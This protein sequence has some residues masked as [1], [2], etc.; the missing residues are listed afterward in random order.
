MR[1]MK[2]FPGTAGPFLLGTAAL[3]VA[4]LASCGGE[5]SERGVLPGE[6]P[7][8]EV[9]AL[10]FDPVGGRLFKVHPHALY[11]SGDGGRSWDPVPLPASVLDGR[12]A[13]IALPPD[14]AGAL[15]VAG[16][17]IGVIVSRDMG[18]TWKGIGQELP[19]DLVALTGHADQPRTLYAVVEEEGIFR[20]QDAG[21]TWTRMDGGPGPPIW[22]FVHT[23]MEGSMQSGWLFAATPE[24]VRRS[25]DCFCGW[26]PTADLPSGGAS[27]VTYDPRRPERVYAS[28]VEG[29]F[30]SPDGGETWERV[31]QEPVATALAVDP[32]TGALYAAVSGGALLRSADEG[33]TWLRV[34]A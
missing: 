7:P 30:L 29:I 10:E 6:A 26:R 3:L 22:A 11:G 20:S 31:S 9:I 4:V 15:Y 16:H 28:T 13:A 5:D 34:G 24:G 19:A 1:G 32:S 33:R 8:G 21:G 14:S 12:I 27:D 2:S 23:D 18:E 17:G 25:M